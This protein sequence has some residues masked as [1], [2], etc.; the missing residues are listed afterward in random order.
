M[1]GYVGIDPEPLTWWRLATMAEGKSREEW[2]HTSSLLWIV[3][4]SK[5]NRKT[6]STPFRPGDFDPYEQRRGGH[7]GNGQRL[8][9]GLLL[10]MKGAFPSED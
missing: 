4:E 7:R 2:K 9:V 1:A 10:A 8:T 6:R 5:R 3:A